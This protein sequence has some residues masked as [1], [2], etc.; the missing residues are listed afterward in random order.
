MLLTSSST[1]LIALVIS[2]SGFQG[3]AFHAPSAAS[4]EWRR[5]NSPCLESST[6]RRSLKSLH[7]RRPEVKTYVGSASGEDPD[8]RGAD[9]PLRYAAYVDPKDA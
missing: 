9:E 2:V 3:K 7:R 8:R 1:C 4:V 5:I 6:N